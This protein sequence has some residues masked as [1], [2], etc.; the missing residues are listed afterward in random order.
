MFNGLHCAPSVP[1][2]SAVEVNGAR[3]AKW[4]T[5]DRDAQLHFQRA[6][7]FNEFASDV[8]SIFISFKMKWPP[9]E[10]IRF[11][12][13]VSSSWNI[14]IVLRSVP[15]FTFSSTILCA[16]CR[17]A[18]TNISKTYHTPT[19]FDDYVLAHCISHTLCFIMRYVLLSA[20]SNVIVLIHIIAG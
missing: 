7:D 17:V 3:L 15:D 8:L 19:R 11:Q 4:L 2:E 10:L 16:G 18:V 13:T 12:I 5:E 9:N 6:D 14:S 1:S 20:P